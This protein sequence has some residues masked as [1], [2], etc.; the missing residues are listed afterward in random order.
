[1]NKKIDQYLL[2]I[3][4]III[5]TYLVRFSVFGIPTTL[6]EILIYLAAIFIIGKKLIT[7]QHLSAPSWKYV[8]PVSLFFLAGV[9]SVIRDP[10]PLLA[11]GYL[12]G[13]IFDPLLFAFLVYNTFSKE[14]IYLLFESLIISATILGVI[15]LASFQFGRLTGFFESANYLAFYLAPPLLYLVFYQ[16]KKL[17]RFPLL[18][19]LIIM[20]LLTRSYGAILSVLVI[21]AAGFHSIIPDLKKKMA[22]LLGAVIILAAFV[23]TQL[24]TEKFQTFLKTGVRSSTSV[25]MEVYQISTSL[26]KNNWPLGVGLR[27]YEA[28]YL[29]HAPDILGR[30]P[31]EWVMLHPHNIYLAIWLFMGIAGLIAFVWLVIAVIKNDL[32]KANLPYLAMLLYFLVHGLIDTPF[33]KNDVGIVFFLIIT[34]LIL[35]TQKNLPNKQGS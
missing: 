32:Q 16:Q 8:L 21:S 10:N 17:W 7:H 5:P 18:V 12:K 4:T 30:P 27:N 29:Q 24:P 20:L 28:T 14:N 26:L 31:L 34:T 22:V 13:F 33:F 19:V 3:L 23:A 1:M 35:S 2:I 6:L 15:S 9:T 25:R 11:L